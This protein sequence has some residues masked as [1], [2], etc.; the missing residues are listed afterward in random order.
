MGNGRQ[1]IKEPLASSQHCSKQLIVGRNELS[2]K[3]MISDV[4]SGRVSV[5]V[6]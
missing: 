2:Q 3:E 6:G 5:V 4:G 1:D